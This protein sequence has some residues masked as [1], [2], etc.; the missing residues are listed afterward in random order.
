MGLR[1]AGSLSELPAG[2]Q[3]ANSDQ[4]GRLLLVMTVGLQG[5]RG[6]QAQS[7]VREG[8]LQGGH[9]DGHAV[10]ATC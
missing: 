6:G 1:T 5:E 9:A 8:A 7:D 3:D 2:A 10:G 4:F